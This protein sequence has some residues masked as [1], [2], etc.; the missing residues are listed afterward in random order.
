MIWIKQWSASLVF[1]DLLWHL[2]SPE[3]TGGPGLATHIIIMYA[4]VNCAACKSALIICCHKLGRNGARQ[5]WSPFVTTL[6]PPAAAAAPR[7][8]CA[9]GPCFSLTL[10]AASP[11][12]NPF[13]SG[14]TA[15]VL[16]FLDP[17]LQHSA[18]AV[19]GAGSVW[20]LASVGTVGET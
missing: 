20:W 7:A 10:T 5:P 9:A 2:C 14:P 4:T 6:I 16:D 8:A 1:L 11:P 19:T 12:P 18:G 15:V 17:V 3:R 13:H